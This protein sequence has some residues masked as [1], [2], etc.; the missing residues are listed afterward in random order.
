MKF[1]PL[2]LTAATLL[3]ADY[4]ILIRNARIIDGS[5]NP[6]YRADV[7]V[8]AGRIASIGRLDATTAGKIID[9]KNRVLTPGFIDVHTHSES[10]IVQ[11]PQAENFLKDGVT[12]VVTG[13]CG[14]SELDLKNFFNELIRQRIGINVATLVGHNTIRR[15]VIG[16]DDRK[17]TPAEIER[18]KAM[19]DKAMQAGAVGFS[20]GL[21]YVPGM[22]SPTEEIVELAKVA[23]KYGG[24]YTSH[25][26]DEGE[27]VLE[28]I[29]EALIVGQQAG[30]R[31]QI[32]HLKQDTKAHWG[33]TQKM[34]DLIER[35]RAQGVEA[36]VDQYPYIAYSTGLGTTL[37][38]WALSGGTEKLKERLQDP[39][40]RK[41]IFDEVLATNK[42]RGYDDFDYTAV[43]ACRFNQ[44]YEGKTVREISRLSGRQDSHESDV[45]TVLDLMA[46][47]GVSVVTKAMSEEDV[48]S[49]MR[50]PNTAIASDGGVVEF[51]DGRPHPRNY[52]TNARVLNE[53]VRLRKILTLEDAIRKMTSLPAQIFQFKDRGLIR[54]GY[55]ADLVL[56]DPA[57]VRDNATFA[58]PHQYST[59]FD[60]VLVNGKI[61]IDNGQ[62]SAERGGKPLPRE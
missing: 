43:A 35:Y 53:Y 46:Q 19:V 36:T 15:E 7:G 8:K 59:G 21:E 9:A 42:K 22:Y 38:N 54:E 26:R 48:A 51:G 4:D 1:L 39:A 34:L 41:K 5:G 61:A 50:Y 25:L 55:A 20:T 10:G 60:V 14:G 40:T 49:I 58:N 29:E 37:P 28:A 57:T 18:M 6:W 3:A 16:S 24:I 62:L 31:V 2:A 27:A 30:A 23:S 52:G 32:S 44:N 33:N 12:T 17:A 13:N 56:F 47:G 45:D 11:R